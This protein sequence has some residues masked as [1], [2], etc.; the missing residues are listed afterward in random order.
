MS[1]IMYRKLF[2]VIILISIFSCAK[3]EVETFA[4]A[5]SEMSYEV[6]KNA[7]KAMN[8]GDFFVAAKKFSE[9]SL[10]LPKMEDAAKASIMSSYCLYLINFYEEATTNLF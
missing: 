3:K 9:S 6:Y 2:F 7:V 4:P 10:I 5:D 1:F 8:D